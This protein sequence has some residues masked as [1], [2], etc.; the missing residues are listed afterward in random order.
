M[1]DYIVQFKLGQIQHSF[2]VVFEK[3]KLVET[4]IYENGKSHQLLKFYL[5]KQEVKATITNLEE[6]EK[7]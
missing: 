1:G 2:A 5:N 6:L 7:V 3:A 4:S